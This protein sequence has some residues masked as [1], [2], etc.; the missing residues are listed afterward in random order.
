MRVMVCA[1]DGRF[2]DRRAERPLRIDVLCRQLQ[3]LFISHHPRR[4][5]DLDLVFGPNINSCK[6]RY[7]ILYV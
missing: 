7:S 1:L 3:S 5:A 2:K 4:D 6:K